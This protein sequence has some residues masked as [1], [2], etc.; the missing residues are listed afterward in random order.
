MKVIYAI[1]NLTN[2][3]KYIGSTVN[4]SRRKQKHLSQLRKNTHHSPRLQN[5]WNKHNP[6]DF[7]FLILEKINDDRDMY[8]VEQEYLDR[9]KKEDISMS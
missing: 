8:D 5:S 6:E 4:F 2:G 3:K 9:Y 1:V 7:K